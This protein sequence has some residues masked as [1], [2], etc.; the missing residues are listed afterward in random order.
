MQVARDSSGACRAA[1]PQFFQV[2]G[3]AHYE[4]AAEARERANNQSQFRARLF[5][6]ADP[7]PKPYEFMEGIDHYN[8]SPENKDK[9]FDVVRAIVSR[10]MHY[11][12]KIKSEGENKLHTK[13][14]RVTQPLAGGLVCS[15]RSHGIGLRS[16][17]ASRASMTTSNTYS[18]V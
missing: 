5:V 2:G 9:P 6:L 16:P 17:S 13:Y 4:T 15:D 10:K 8:D 7:I 11:L 18:T 12:T 3:D 14:H 1:P